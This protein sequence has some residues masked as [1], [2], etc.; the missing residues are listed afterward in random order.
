MET[1]EH[2][3]PDKGC[4]YLEC[5]EFNVPAVPVDGKREDVC[6]ESMIPGTNS[7]HAPA[8]NTY[9]WHNIHGNTNRINHK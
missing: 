5:K 2:S 6:S 7:R 1:N 3:N 8:K 4:F 9:L